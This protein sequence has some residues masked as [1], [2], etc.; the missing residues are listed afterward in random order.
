[1]KSLTVENVSKLYRLGSASDL[2]NENDSA[3]V[4][5]LK[6]PLNNYRKYRSLYKFTEA[7]LSGKEP[8]KDI[9]WALR[10]VSFDVE[11]GEVVGLVGHI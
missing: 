7:E 5:M 9:L 8:R 3:L 10:D 11:P 6:R 4:R 1:M 2:D